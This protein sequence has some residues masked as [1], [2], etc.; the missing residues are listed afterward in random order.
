M[1]NNGSVKAIR[2][3]LTLTGGGASSSLLVNDS[4]ATTQD[5]V[6]VTPTQVGSAVGDLLFG[7]GGS[8]T[9]GS[10]GSLTLDL[11]KGFDDVVILTPSADT[12]F[13][14][15][16]SLAAFQA[17][18]GAFLNLDLTGVTNPV[19]NPSA[20]G[21]GQWTFGNRQAVTFTNIASPIQD[22]TAQL[23]LT[24]G[25][26]VLDPVTNHFKQAVTL[27]NTSSQPTVGPVSLVLDGLTAGVKLVNATGTTLQQTPAGSPFVD[28][29]LG[30]NVLGAGEAFVVVLEFDSPTAAIAYTAR[31]LAGSGSR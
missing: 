30:D 20:P 2:S 9:Y 5:K 10:F 13:T 28:V 17:G 6:T 19:N 3:A 12:A 21:A 7:T 27:F 22:V 23:S 14:V 29:A 8:L 25:S 24:F 31:V 11:S 26:F 4:L 15:N 18:H 1:A 16:G